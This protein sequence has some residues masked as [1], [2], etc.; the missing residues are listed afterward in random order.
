MNGD[1]VDNAL[2]ALLHKR[3]HHSLLLRL[4]LSGLVSGGVPVV[5]SL[6]LLALGLK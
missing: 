3:N 5:A 6:V 1:K 2:H 4:H